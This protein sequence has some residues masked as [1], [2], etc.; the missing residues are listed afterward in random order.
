MPASGHL[1]SVSGNRDD[2]D[3]SILGAFHLLN[4]PKTSQARVG[5]KTLL[6][7]FRHWLFECGWLEESFGA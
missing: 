6:P 5:P 7:S 1:D 3:Y 4:Q 2:F